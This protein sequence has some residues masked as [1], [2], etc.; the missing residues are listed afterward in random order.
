M[1]VILLMGLKNMVKRTFGDFQI[2]VRDI[3]IGLLEEKYD[4][5]IEWY[6]YIVVQDV[7]HVRINEKHVTVNHVYQTLDKRVC[8][9]YDSPSFIDDVL[10][11][12]HGRVKLDVKVV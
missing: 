6:G 11:A 10:S 1:V 8:V 3:L 4:D 2:G 9:Y 5:V 12:V 7:V